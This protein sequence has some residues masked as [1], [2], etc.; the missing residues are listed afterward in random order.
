MTPPP[1]CRSG[2]G[3]SSTIASAAR[4]TSTT[5][6]AAH[7][8]TGTIGYWIDERYAGQV[9]AEG[10]VVVFEFAFERLWL[11]RLEINIVP[12]N[13]N[14]RRVMEKLDLRV[15]GVAVRMLEI[16]GVW[17]DH[18]RCAITAEEWQ[19]PRS[20]ASGGCSPIRRRRAGAPTRQ[21]CSAARRIASAAPGA[22]SCAASTSSTSSGADRER[23][24]SLLRATSGSR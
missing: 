24:S 19:A 10:V 16:N 3:C 18:V 12:R 5:S 1:G 4:S 23:F 15:E 2:S 6:S 9:V 20:C 8:Q 22:S 14:S 13:T 7:C 21:S 17:E 11:H